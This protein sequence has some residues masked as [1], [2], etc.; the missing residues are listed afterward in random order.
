[1]LSLEKLARLYDIHLLIKQEK[2]NSPVEL[3][4]RFC[5]SRSHLYNIL[6]ELE[7]YGAVIKYSRKHQTFYYTNDF[8]I[9]ET[10]FWEREIK[11]FFEKRF[12]VHFHWTEEI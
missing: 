12:S 9:T 4:A 6:E 7:D 11:Y 5:I 10:V 1:M 8:E 3:A 2:T